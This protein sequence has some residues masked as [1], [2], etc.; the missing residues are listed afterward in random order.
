MKRRTHACSEVLRVASE[1]YDG[2]AQLRSVTEHSGDTL[3][4]FIKR[5]IDDVCGTIR[6]RQLAHAE[7]INALSTAS[8]QLRIIL[9]ALE[10]SF[11]KQ[12]EPNA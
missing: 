1:A 9:V 11:N 4:L 10:R 7:A 8:Y 12:E 6:N 2:G 5:E 3:A